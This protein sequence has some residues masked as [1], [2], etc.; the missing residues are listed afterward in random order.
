[1]TYHLLV[2]RLDTQWPTDMQDTRQFH[3]EIVVVTSQAY[4]FM[5]FICNKHSV[6]RSDG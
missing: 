2:R 1:M 4:D 5:E 3:L 6:S